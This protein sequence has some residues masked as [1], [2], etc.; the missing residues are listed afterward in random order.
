VITKPYS[1][2]EMSKKI[3]TV[4]HESTGS[5]ALASAMDESSEI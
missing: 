2:S 5:R 4:L 3:A 1:P